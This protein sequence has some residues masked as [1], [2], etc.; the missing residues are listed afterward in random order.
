MIKKT[1]TLELFEL[2]TENSGLTL[3]EMLLKQIE[4]D[5]KVKQK[6]KEN[7]NKFARA[8]MPLFFNV[9]RNI[10]KEVDENL[11]K[12]RVHFNFIN[13]ELVVPFCAMGTDSIHFRWD[14]YTLHLPVLEEKITLNEGYVSSYYGENF[15]VE[16]I[17]IKRRFDN[18]KSCHTISLDKFKEI[19][20]ENFFY[21][22]RGIRNI[23]FFRTDNY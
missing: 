2:N 18:D 12:E 21:N 22:D 8:L 5:E 11:N 1:I 16:D 13:G 7:N 4:E 14:K 17:K 23:E 15:S 10:A 20:K 9:I 6:V 19:Y 3:K